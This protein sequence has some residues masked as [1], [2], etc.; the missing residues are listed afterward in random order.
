MSPKSSES[1]FPTSS[2]GHRSSERAIAPR[3][4]VAGRR[5]IHSPTMPRRAPS[6]HQ[7]RPAREADHLAVGRLLGVLQAR[8]A[9]V[10]PG[11]FAPHV[12]AS[13]SGSREALRSLLVAPSTFVGVAERVS[14]LEA[15]PRGGAVLVGLVVARVHETPAD[16]SLRS[17]R[18]VHV[19]SLI[20][21][22]A[23]RR[24]GVGADLLLVVE[25]WARARGAE[26]V[27]L[28]VWEGNDEADRFY[29]ALGFRQASRVLVRELA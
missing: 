10:Q 20:V 6:P 8:H 16:P 3:A 5:R 14:T 28:T 15:A 1:A 2:Y 26:Q 12:G 29:D 9:E 4:A 25:R 22:P 11:F 27:V 17:R 18:R 23:H 7:T 21:D 19:E 13:S 24:L